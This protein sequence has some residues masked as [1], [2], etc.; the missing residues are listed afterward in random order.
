MASKWL[1]ARTKVRHTRTGRVEPGKIEVFVRV[2]ETDGTYRN[3]RV[4]MD[5]D[6]Y[7]KVAVLKP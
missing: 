4:V 5:L 7:R 6:D 2:F 3:D 1:D